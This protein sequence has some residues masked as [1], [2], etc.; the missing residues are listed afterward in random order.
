MSE[1]WL[2]VVGYED[3]YKVSD[4]GRVRSLERV[5]SFGRAYRTVHGKVLKGQQDKLGYWRVV[6]SVGNRQATRLVAHLVLEAFIGPRLEGHQCCHGPNGPGDNRLSQLCW[7]TPAKNSGEDKLRDGTY[8]RGAQAP[9]AIIDSDQKVISICTM[10]A[11]REYT[12]QQVADMFGVCGEAITR[13]WNGKNWAHVDVPRKQDM[14]WR[15]ESCGAL[16]N[17]VHSDKRFCGGTCKA[18]AY[19]ARVAA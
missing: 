11:S 10:L 3:Y 12:Q 14:E 6:L 17:V 2:P 13:I 15:C 7:G 18:R 9:S 1:T 8:P 16:L 19:R 4:L 5:V